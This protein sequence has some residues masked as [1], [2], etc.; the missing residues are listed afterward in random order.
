MKKKQKVSGVKALKLNPSRIVQVGIRCF[1]LILIFSSI[2]FCIPEKKNSNKD[3]ML[4]AW[5]VGEMNSFKEGKVFSNAKYL[6]G[7]LGQVEYRGLDFHDN[8]VFNGVGKYNWQEAGDATL[9][10]GVTL[11]AMAWK[12]KNTRDPDTLA[13]IKRYVNYYKLMQSLNGGGLGRNFVNVEAYDQFLPCNKNGT[14]G[15]AP[16]NASCGTMRY[17]DYTFEDQQYKFRYDFSL[18][19]VIHS[20]VGLYWTYVFV[21]ELKPDIVRICTD[22]LGYYEANNYQV[23]DV[24]NVNLRYGDHNPGTNPVAKIN[25]VILKYIA[26]GQITDLGAWREVITLGSV[27]AGLIVQ[28]ED[29]NFFNHYMLIKGVGVLVHLGYPLQNG[30]KNL[31]SAVKDQGHELAESMDI[32][33][34][35]ASKIHVKDKGGFPLFNYHCLVDQNFT[36]IIGLFDRKPYNKWEYSPLRRCIVQRSSAL[37]LNAGFLEAYWLW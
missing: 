12:Y 16:D 28:V 3:I 15:V 4:L 22:L 19:A 25:E 20:L 1:S 37:G 6:T 24:N 17:S 2:S 5:L 32:Y 34:F 9:N 23:R 31:I 27:F 35:Q 7:P 26:R 8:V 13:L 21:D 11:H 14:V 30:L 29:A 18:D 10:V 36:D 33:F